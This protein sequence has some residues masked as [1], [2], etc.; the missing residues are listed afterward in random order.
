[1]ASNFAFAFLDSLGMLINAMVTIFAVFFRLLTP[2]LSLFLPLGALSFVSS[3]LSCF[4]VHVS[5]LTLLLEF[6][7]HRSGPLRR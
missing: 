4:F 5:L 7:P 6:A 3:P 1:M 2:Y